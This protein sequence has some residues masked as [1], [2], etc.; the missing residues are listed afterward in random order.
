MSDSVGLFLCHGYEYEVVSIAIF[1]WREY[2]AIDR[3]MGLGWACAW[4]KR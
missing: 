3:T 4:R 1:R 2:E